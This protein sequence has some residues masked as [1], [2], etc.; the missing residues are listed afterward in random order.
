MSRILI[1]I[2]L[3]THEH[4]G[5]TIGPTC[6]VDRVNPIPYMQKR[7]VDR[8]IDKIRL[9]SWSQWLYILVVDQFNIKCESSERSFAWKLISSPCP[10][11]TFLWYLL[12]FLKLFI[13]QRKI[14]PT[15]TCSKYCVSFFCHNANK[16]I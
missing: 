9:S 5:D 8:Q 4:R 16:P 14:R 6:P 7:A 13:L 15:T 3:T 11:S 12:S 1:H 2:S 10:V